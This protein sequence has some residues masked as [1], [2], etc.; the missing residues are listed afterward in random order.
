MKICAPYCLK[1][2]SF[3]C[4]VMST[5]FSSSPNVSS[6]ERRARSRVYSE[7]N[8]DELRDVEEENAGSAEGSTGMPLPDLVAF[9]DRS[10]SAPT[11]LMR[12][13]IRVGRQLRRISDEFHLTYHDQQVGQLQ[14]LQLTNQTGLP[15][16]H[17]P[18][19]SPFFFSILFIRTLVIRTF[20]FH[21]LMSMQLNSFFFSCYPSVM[22]ISTATW[23]ICKFWVL[24][25]W[26]CSY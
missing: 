19:V 24:P 23:C 10:N 13:E 26:N 22:P 14:P 11:R 1:I 18:P 5:T 25:L 2:R 6:A 21:H 8:S 16:P 9:R 4:T 12:P 7:N 3:M 15:Q 20:V 17:F